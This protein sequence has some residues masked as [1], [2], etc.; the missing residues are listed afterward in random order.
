MSE[1]RRE[2]GGPQTS[3]DRRTVKMSFVIGPSDSSKGSIPRFWN[4]W[5]QHQV[6]RPAFVGGKKET[7][8]WKL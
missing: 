7:V 1:G 8:D 3:G 2:T 5:K 4:A 6:G